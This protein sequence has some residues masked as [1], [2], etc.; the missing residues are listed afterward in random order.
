MKQALRIG[1]IGSKFMGRAHS[2]AWKKAGL[3]FPV[4]LHPVLQVAC[5]R[6]Q[7]SLSEFATQ[8]GWQQTETEWRNETPNFGAGCLLIEA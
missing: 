7:A 4:P 5:A 3:F 1:L 2:N 6:H 8:R